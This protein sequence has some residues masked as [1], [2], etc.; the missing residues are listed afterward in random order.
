MGS[1]LAFVE[2]LFLHLKCDPTYV[3][4]I[5]PKTYTYLPAGQ[6]IIAAAQGAVADRVLEVGVGLV[7]SPEDPAALAHT[8]VD[9]YGRPKGDHARMGRTA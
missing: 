3:I 6:P 7:C 8:I 9:L 1:Y 5:P 2:A 4:T